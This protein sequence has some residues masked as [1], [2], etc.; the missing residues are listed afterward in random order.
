MLN[1]ATLSFFLV[2]GEY[3]F[4]IVADKMRGITIVFVFFTGSACISPKMVRVDMNTWKQEGNYFY[5]ALQTE[6]PRGG[7]S[8]VF[9]QGHTRKLTVAQG[10]VSAKR[11]HISA[12]AEPGA[13]LALR[14]VSGP[15]A[16][17]GWKQRAS[18]LVVSTAVSERQHGWLCRRQG[19]VVEGSGVQARAR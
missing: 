12:R 5:F 15:S 10:H 9:A 13:G 19:S 16:E 17:P 6:K 7:R 4:V 11:V 14:L 8:E 1:A 3:Y 2:S 18:G